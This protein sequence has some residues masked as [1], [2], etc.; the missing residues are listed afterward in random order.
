MDW[1]NLEMSKANATDVAPSPKYF[2]VTE[3]NAALPLVRRIA[4]D[5]VEQYQQVLEL[6]TR[7]QTALDQDDEEELEVVDCARREATA[8][9]NELIAELSDIGV[10][11]KDWETGLVDFLG[12]REGRDVYW[13]W[14]LGEEQVQ[15]WHEIHAGM[16]GRALLEE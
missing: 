12:Q 4:E 15:Y 8:R 9:L 14:R 5:I 13:C 3:A 16:A 1:D 2:T 10:E 7:Q 11:L 6:H